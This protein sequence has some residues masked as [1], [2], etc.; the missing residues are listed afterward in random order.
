MTDDQIAL[1]QSSFA[2]VVPRS[3][4]VATMF[5]DRLF[6]MAPEYRELFPEDMEA[7]R[8][9]LMTTLAAVVQS[10]TNL[11]AIVPVVQD[12]GRRHVGYNVK[13]A[14]YEPVGAALLWTLETGLGDD[15]TDNTRDAWA[16]A[17]GLLSTVMIAA[18]E[19]ASAA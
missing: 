10:L 7:Q 3:N 4:V 13:P 16:A 5:Y 1:I 19:E 14:D 6:E 9:K 12:L 17:Y 11:D 15:W 18:A 2:K 8:G